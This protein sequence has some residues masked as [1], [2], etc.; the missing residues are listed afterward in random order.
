VWDDNGTLRYDMTYKKGEKAGTW[1][2]WDEKG[3]LIMEK[4]Y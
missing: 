1:Y 3:N 2:M 4:S